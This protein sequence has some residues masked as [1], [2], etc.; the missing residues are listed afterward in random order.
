[1]KN[2]I[3]LIIPQSPVDWS[4]FIWH[5][6]NKIVY[7]P[8][9][10]RRLGKSLGINLFPGTKICNYNCVYCDCGN[11]QVEKFSFLPLDEIKKAIKAG[12]EEAILNNTPIDYITF[13][14]NGEPTLY[15]GFA[16]IVDYICKIRTDLQLYK[17]LA[18]FTNA[19]LLHKKGV[20][21]AVNKIDAVFVKIDAGNNETFDKISGIQGKSAFK[22][23]IANTKLLKNYTLSSAIIFNSGFENIN[24]FQKQSFIQILKGINPQMVTF[25]TIEYPTPQPFE[26]TVKRINLR[27]TMEKM[28]N[29]SEFI[30]ANGFEVKAY[31]RREIC[32]DRL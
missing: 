17:P 29:L 13:A 28:L 25:Y 8:V 9:D 22:K 14:G 1:M 6:K 26:A 32:D 11:N 16:E 12:L 20:S 15:P 10:S 31:I 30:A 7:G 24:T 21:N 27:D 23:V 19:T 5:N 3:S 2:K 4:N 18:I